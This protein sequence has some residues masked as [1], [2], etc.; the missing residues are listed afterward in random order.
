[1][2]QPM[3]LQRVGRG[4]ETEQQNA[5]QGPAAMLV[6]C[7]ERFIQPSQY[8]I[9]TPVSRMNTLRRDRVLLQPRWSCSGY[10]T[11]TSHTLPFKRF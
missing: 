4:L 7:A 8:P 5:G 11:I 6:R 9:T 10:H 3:G 1:M 2:L